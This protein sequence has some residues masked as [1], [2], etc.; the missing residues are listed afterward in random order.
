ME[1][2]LTQYSIGDIMIFVILLA[3]AVKEAVTFY[4]W[5]RDRVKKVTDKDY[6]TK[7]EQEELEKQVEGLEKFYAE[8]DRV[9]K[10]FDEIHEAIKKINSQIDMLIDSDKNDIKA[11]ITREH[12]YYVHDKKWIDDYTME[13]IENRF[14]VYEKEHGNSF[15]ETFV[16][17]LRRLPRKPPDNAGQQPEE[18]ARR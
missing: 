11:Y 12:H 2:L 13:C 15:V 1:D 10:G 8:K 7:K 9:D 14:L 17:E 16:K 5:A 18:S 4:D 6:K 3:F